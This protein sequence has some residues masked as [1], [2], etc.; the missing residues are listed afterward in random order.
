MGGGGSVFVAVGR[1]VG[2][3]VE[4]GVSINGVGVKEGLSSIVGMGV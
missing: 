1:G 4:V 3:L 2:V